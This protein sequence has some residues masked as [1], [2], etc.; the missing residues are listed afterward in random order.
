MTTMHW[1]HTLATGLA[2]VFITTGAHA[3]DQKDLRVQFKKE[4]YGKTKCV[5]A[6]LP[7]LDVPTGRNNFDVPTGLNAAQ[8][9]ACIVD[10]TFI[11]GLCRGKFAVLQTDTT[12]NGDASQS[13]QRLC[14]LAGKAKQVPIPP[15]K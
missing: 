8:I 10:F 4:V 9:K 1:T 12:K 2:T 15:G 14:Q 13:N 7:F 6:F 5:A 3:D 11:D